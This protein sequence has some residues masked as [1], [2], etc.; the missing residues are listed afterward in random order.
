MN[1][2]NVKV[3]QTAEQVGN[4]ILNLEQ[5]F[6]KAFEWANAT[7]QGV[8]DTRDFEKAVLKRCHVYYDLLP[9]MQDR[10]NATALATNED[11]DLSGND[12]KEKKEDDISRSDEKEKNNEESDSDFV[13]ETNDEDDDQKADDNAKANDNSQGS[14]LDEKGSTRGSDNESDTDAFITPIAKK[15]KTENKKVSGPRY[16]AGKKDSFDKDKFFQASLQTRRAQVDEQACHNRILEIG[17]EAE[18][19]IKQ[20]EDK[21]KMVE[22]A[23]KQEEMT[24]KH[25]ERV[26]RLREKGMQPHAILLLFPELKDIVDVL[27]PK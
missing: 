26:E 14:Y 10:A 23:E 5:K 15:R 3:T 13:L 21:I 20:T 24:M 16:S 1:S 18:T 11:E 9:I 17:V 2:A 12:E 25:I 6:R 7:G 27:F 4:K 22:L 19:K 8:T